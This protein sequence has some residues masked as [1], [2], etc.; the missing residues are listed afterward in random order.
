MERLA[1]SM[2]SF[3]ARQLD[4]DND[5]NEQLGY[6]AF[7]LL[8]SIVVL[9]GLSILSYIVGTGTRALFIALV[10]ASL[11][12]VSGG[13]HLDG[14]ARCTVI[15]ILL[16]TAGGLVAKYGDIYLRALPAWA[17]VI[18]LIM[19]AGGAWWQFYLHAPVDNKRRRLS[20]ARRA[21]L[22]RGSL[23]LSAIYALLGSLLAFAGSGWAWIVI[24]GMWL[25]GFT[26]TS[27]GH[28]VAQQVDA[29]FPVRLARR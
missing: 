20:S 15:S 6:G 27:A 11:R 9:G 7:I 18:L 4:L 13:A 5:R 17:G 25:Q 23:Q 29:L 21:Q 8:Q 24:N 22:R 2:G 28:L 1:K 19:L 10:A 16:F 3:L 26:M 14:P 12:A